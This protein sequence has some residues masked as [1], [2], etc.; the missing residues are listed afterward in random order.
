M[1]TKL[2]AKIAFGVF[3]EM[4]SEMIEEDNVIPLWGKYTYEHPFDGFKHINVGKFKCEIESHLVYN[5]DTGYVMGMV[6]CNCCGKI[7]TLYIKY[8]VDENG[9]ALKRPSPRIEFR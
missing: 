9:R 3:K 4:V 6:F 8:K 5:K 7:T 2:S 1:V